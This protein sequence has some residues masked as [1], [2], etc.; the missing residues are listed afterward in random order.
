MITTNQD[1]VIDSAI[2][3]RI[4]GL[5]R[6]KTR[7]VDGSDL[8][9]QV[10]FDLSGTPPRA[11]RNIFEREWMALTQPSLWQRASIDNTCLVMHCPLQDVAALLLPMLKSVV[12][13]TN[14]SFMKYAQEQATV[15]EHSEE[16]WVS[17]RKAVDEMATLLHFD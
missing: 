10:Y 1:M 7:K 13:A 2:D 4:V 3:M 9:Y 14:A 11:W 17:E 15:D 5:N 16:V 8:A 6:E 12:A